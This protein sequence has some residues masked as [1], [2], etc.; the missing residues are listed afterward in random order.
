M[1][2]F[3]E[4]KQ[5]HFDDACRAFANTHKGK[6]ADIAERIS[7]SQQMLRNKLNPEQPHQLTCVDLMRLTDETEDPT[8]L[9]GWL[10][11]MQ[12]QPSVPVNEISNEKMP[13]YVMSA[14]AE[15][16]KLAAE[17][18]AGGHMNM[19][20]IADFKRTVNSAVRCLT[21][22]GITMQA[23]V[24]SNPTLSSAVDALTGIGATLGMN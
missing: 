6:I 11:Q 3:R 12:C 9:D 17:T 23:R 22:A 1:F 19:A 7:M 20:R 10:A 4:S 14:T 5:S 15:V 8:L 24:Q 18:V 16:G 13:V 2:D 21:L